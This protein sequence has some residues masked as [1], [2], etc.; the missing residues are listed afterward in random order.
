MVST[1]TIWEALKVIGTWGGE[2]VKVGECKCESEHIRSE[3]VKANMGGVKKA[4]V[5]MQG[6]KVKLKEVKLEEAR[7][8]RIQK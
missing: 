1:T 5:N 3:K 4:K 7:S 2:R 8:G 6:V